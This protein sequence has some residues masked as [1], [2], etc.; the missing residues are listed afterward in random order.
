MFDLNGKLA[1]VTGSSRGIGKAIAIKLAMAGCDVIVHGRSN[2]DALKETALEIEKLGRKAYTVFCDTSDVSQIENMFKQIKDKFGYIDIMVNNAAILYRTPFMEISV[3][4]WDKIMET[5]ARGYFLCSQN[6]AKL[7]MDKKW[8][9]IINIS[10]ISQ[11]ETAPNRVHYCVSK[12]AI[13]MLTKGLALELA[14]YGIT[15]NTVLPG[16]IHTD[17]NDDVLSDPDYYKNCVDGIPLG[18]IGKADDIAGAVVMLASD[19][20]SYTTG[21]EIVIDGGKTVF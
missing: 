9:R 17:F 14:P 4:E 8:G 13:G 10:S 19:E 15:A 18:R 11:L 5:N 16:S 12:A 7:M 6:A 1:L 3:D 21:A 2:S 20:A